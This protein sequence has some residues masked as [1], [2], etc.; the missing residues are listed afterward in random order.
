MQRQI[1]LPVPT[2]TFGLANGS[3][4]RL[5][6]TVAAWA[7]MISVPVP[8]GEGFSLALL[9]R[10]LLSISPNCNTHVSI[11]L[12]TGRKFITR[13]GGVPYASSPLGTSSPHVKVTTDM[14]QGA[15]LPPTSRYASEKPMFLTDQKTFLAG[16]G[17][18]STFPS[19]FSREEHQ[20]ATLQNRLATLSTPI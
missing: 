4:I 15:V 10:Q 13:R 19:R 2:G 8:M 16:G 5:F 17:C 1:F 6:V 7:Y 20:L 14:I 9:H 18:P 11:D 3:R 12:Q